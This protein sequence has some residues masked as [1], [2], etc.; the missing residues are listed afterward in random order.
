MRVLV[1]EDDALLGPLVRRG[2]EQQRFAVDLAA[3]LGRAAELLAVTTY[4][5]VCL[6]LGLPDGDGLELCR[7]LRMSGGSLHPPNGLLILTARDAVTD[8][9]D[10]LDSGADD[11][12]VKPFELVELV[13]RVRAVGRRRPGRSPKLTVGD[14][15]VDEVRHEVC[16]GERPLDLTA[17]EFMVLRYLAVHAGEAVSAERLLEHCWDVHADDLTTSVRVILSRVRRKLG[18]PQL[19]HTIAGVG[20]RLA[21]EP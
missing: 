10:G 15:T 13:A 14:L 12:L 1:V 6:D 21:V 2:L 17:K 8:R 3:T 20:Y 18:E 11:Y 16:R 4:D 7:A 9:V 19:V 5:V